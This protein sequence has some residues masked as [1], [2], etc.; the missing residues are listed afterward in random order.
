MLTQMTWIWNQEISAMPF[1]ILFLL[2]SSWSGLLHENLVFEQRQTVE[3]YPTAL[4][5]LAVHGSCCSV[6]HKVGWSG[7]QHWAHHGGTEKLLSVWIKFSGWRRLMG[8]VDWWKWKHCAPW[9]HFRRQRCCVSC[10][11]VPPQGAEQ[12]SSLTEHP[13]QWH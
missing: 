6:L 1:N 9:V 7:W 5:G 2:S 10:S 12:H 8:W 4:R 13:D 11:L 3:L